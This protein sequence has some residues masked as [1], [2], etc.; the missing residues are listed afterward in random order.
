MNQFYDTF[1][2]TPLNILR[3]SNRTILFKYYLP[4][5]SKN[6][7]GFLKGITDSVRRT[8]DVM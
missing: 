6:P 5:V 4:N 3:G 1:Y 8:K 7:I 2:E